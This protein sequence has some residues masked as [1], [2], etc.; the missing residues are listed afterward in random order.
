M[1]IRRPGYRRTDP[2][3][4]GARPARR[5]PGCRRRDLLH[6]RCRGGVRPS[7]RTDEG[8]TDAQTSRTCARSRRP[9]SCPSEPRRQG[10][11]MSSPTERRSRASHA[12]CVISAAIRT[13]TIPLA[14]S[15]RS[16]T[17]CRIL[18]VLR[19][20]DESHLASLSNGAASWWRPGLS[21][22]GARGVGQEPCRARSLARTS[23]AGSVEG[24]GTGFGASTGCASCP[25]HAWRSREGVGAYSADRDHLFRGL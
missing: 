5:R 11:R 16:F 3:L 2:R 14:H 6:R 17:L 24:W 9:I 18:T 15:R 10:T 22:P 19:T 7:L 1:T 21:P 13:K 4:A 23:E 20:R 25:L 12:T 8:A